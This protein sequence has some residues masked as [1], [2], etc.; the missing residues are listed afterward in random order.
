ML[1]LAK[2]Y[3]E[4]VRALLTPSATQPAELHPAGNLRAGVALAGFLYSDKAEPPP[5][6]SLG[7]P[8]HLEEQVEAVPT[9]ARAVSEVF[10]D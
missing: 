9:R 6:S 4:S 3:P 10:K 8:G 2:V 1:L 7:L 5:Q